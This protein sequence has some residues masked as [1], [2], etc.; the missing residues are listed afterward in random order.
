MRGRLCI[1]PNRL[2]IIVAAVAGLFVPAGAAAHDYWLAQEPSTLAIGDTCSIRLLVGDRLESE[3]E[4]PLQSEMT[5]RYEWLSAGG[6]VNLLESLPE[7]TKPVLQRT[8]TRAETALLIMDRDFVEIETTYGQF[9]EFLAHE[10]DTDLL[11]Q[12]KDIPKD[13]KMRRRYARNL[14]ALVR[15][16]AGDDTPIHDRKVG[17]Q[18]EILLLDDPWSVPHGE[19][20]RA[21]VLF[22]GKPLERKWVRNFVGGQAGLLAESKALTDRNGSVGFPVEHSG[23]WVVRVAYVRRCQDCEGTVWDTYYA[24]LSVSLPTLSRARKEH[25]GR[26]ATASSSYGAHPAIRRGRQAS[27]PWSRG[28]PELSDP[29]E[30]S[31]VGL[32]GTTR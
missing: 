13:T 24:T 30:P 25:R 20:L 22:E 29:Y 4:R 17:Q 8:V 31:A 28:C 5:T 19:M 2:A 3:L 18:L 7:G 16:G 32:R 21:Q 15:V 14:K 9:T 27:A 10:N 26:S 11:Q 23:Q 1:A 12:V 6:S